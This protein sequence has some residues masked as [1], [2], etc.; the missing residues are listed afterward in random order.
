MDPIALVASVVSGLLVEVIKEGSKA[1]AKDQPKPLQSIIQ[2]IREKLRMAGTA[3]LLERVE[4]NPNPRNVEI[5][6]GEILEQMNSDEDFLMEIRD[7]LEKLKTEQGFSNIQKVISDL[8]D[9][10]NIQ[11]GDIKQVSNSSSS[12]QVVAEKIKGV[13]NITIGNVTQNS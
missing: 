1:L 3:G 12:N 4:N 5:L 6:E 11:L 8:E 7:F 9:V 10:E 2:S 13:T